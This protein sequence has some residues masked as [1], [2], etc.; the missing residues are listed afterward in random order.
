MRIH[1][2]RAKQLV[3]ELSKR[4]WW[5]LGHQTFDSYP[6]YMCNKYA[7]SITQNIR[8]NPSKSIDENI[9]RYFKRAM[10]RIAKYGV[11]KFIVFGG[12]SGIPIP[13]YF[14][15]YCKQNGVQIELVS[16]DENMETLV[17]KLS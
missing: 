6:Y 8:L 9:D 3:D 5:R 7:I 16:D 1:I 12:G 11:R 15:D 14:I 4:G 17:H 2:D 10:S 13:Q